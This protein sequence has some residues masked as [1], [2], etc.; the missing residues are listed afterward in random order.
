MKLAFYL[1]EFSWGPHEVRNLILNYVYESVEFTWFLH[2]I[3]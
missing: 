3:Y 2:H 1:G